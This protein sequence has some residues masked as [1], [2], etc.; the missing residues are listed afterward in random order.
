M[1]ETKTSKREMR[2]EKKATRGTGKKA[3]TDKGRS[4]YISAR[5]TELKS[6]RSKLIEERKGLMAARRAAKGKTGA[7]KDEA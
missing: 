6:E 3:E 7:A 1:D 2:A 5:L 4:K